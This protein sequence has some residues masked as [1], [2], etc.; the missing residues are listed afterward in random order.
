MIQHVSHAA[1]RGIEHV[2]I[3]V[4][5]HDEALRFFESAFGAIRLFSLVKPGAA[6]MSAAEVGAKNGLLSGLKIVSLSMLRLANGPNI[7][8]FQIDRPRRHD[9]TN[10]G[11]I[12]ITHIS[13]TIDDLEGVTARFEAAGGTLLEGPYPLSG[14]EEGAGNRGRFGLTPWGLLIE[15]ESFA[16]PIRYNDGA[17]AERWLPS[18]LSPT[19]TDERTSE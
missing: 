9:A 10:I 7:E 14:Q 12:G 17:R 16:E 2:G 5:D 4:P 19:E 13:L 1:P 15:F 11:D 18:G 8:V 3:T 6:P